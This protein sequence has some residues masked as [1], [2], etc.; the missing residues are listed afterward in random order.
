[1]Q[2]P[3]TFREKITS[4]QEVHS[5]VCSVLVEPLCQRTHPT[6]NWWRGH[7]CFLLLTTPIVR[8]LTFLRLSFL[9]L[10]LCPVCS[11]LFVL[12]KHFIWPWACILLCSTDFHGAETTTGFL[13]NVHSTGSGLVIDTSFSVWGKLVFPPD[14]LRRLSPIFLSVKIGE[15]LLNCFC[16]RLATQ[17]SLLLRE[18][19]VSFSCWCRSFSPCFY[20]D[21]QH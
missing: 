16:T 6:I 1:M 18:I 15:N 5:K 14:L 19:P 3:R 11:V 17:G 9:S 8:A 21:V 7:F 10:S 2:H 13:Y 4:M 12:V 20:A